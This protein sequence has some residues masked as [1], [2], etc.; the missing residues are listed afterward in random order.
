[1]WRL[2]KLLIISRPETR[3]RISMRIGGRGLPGL[4][5][6]PQLSLLHCLYNWH[7][8]KWWWSLAPRVRQ[9]LTSVTIYHWNKSRSLNSRDHLLTKIRQRGPQWVVSGQ[10]SITEPHGNVIINKPEIFLS[11]HIMS[12]NGSSLLPRAQPPGNW[13]YSSL[14]GGATTINQRDKDNLN[15]QT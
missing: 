9:E 4:D 7:Y 11:R 10:Q 8:C 1:M 5:T 3:D 2:S 6:I 13:R 12:R 15:G 14:L